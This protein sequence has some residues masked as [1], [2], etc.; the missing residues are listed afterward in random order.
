MKILKRADLILIAAL[1]LLGLVVFI[2]FRAVPGREV[3]VSVRIDGNETA[4]YPISQD[5]TFKIESGDDDYNIL[6]IVNGTA[7]VS[8]SNCKN[9]ICVK[10][11][12]KSQAGEVIVCLPHKVVFVLESEN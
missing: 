9:Q 4:R 12:K 2:I 7:Y 10:T 3:Y 8:E 5:G 11:G 6:T 1:L